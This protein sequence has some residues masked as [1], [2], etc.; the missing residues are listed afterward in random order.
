MYH[1]SAVQPVIIKKVSSF[2]SL[3]PFRREHLLIY[4]FSGLCLLLLAGCANQS[5]DNQTTLTSADQGKT[6]TVHAGDKVIIQLDENPTTGYTWAVAST[7]TQILKLQ[8][9]GYTA[10]P[11]GRV[12]SG[13]TRIFTFIAQKSGTTPLQLKYWRSFEGDRS[14][15]Q[16]FAVTIQVQ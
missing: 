13:G 5:G 7:D 16:H 12:G 8:D 1:K 9:S 15:V 2:H 10:T 4:L 11:T 14:I 3:V 6:I